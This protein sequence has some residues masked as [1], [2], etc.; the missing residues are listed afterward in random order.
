MVTCRFECRNYQNPANG[1]TVAVYRTRERN[2]VPM[3][4][5]KSDN[6]TWVSFTA[7]GTELPDL[8]S[9][10]IE[11]EGKW[12]NSERFGGQL[13]ADWF[14]VLLPKSRQ[15][16]VTYLSSMVKGIGPVMAETIVDRFGTDTFEVLE[17]EPE[18]LLEIK[19]ITEAK[20][21]AI[22]ESYGSSAELRELMTYLAPYRVTP[23]K[24]EK[25][26]EH[27]GLE[28]VKILQENPYRLCEIKGFGFL[29]VDP[30][31][32]AS[33]H[34]APDQPERVKAAL[35]YVLKEAE[36]DGH[37]YL[38]SQ[39]AVTKAERL[40][41]K[42]L[43]RGMVSR[44]VIIRAGNE[45]VLEDKLLQADKS[46]IFLKEN[47]EAEQKAVWNLIRLMKAGV[48]SYE[49][50]SELTEAQ[51][52]QG[53]VLAEK[54]REAVRMVFRS[55]V[56]IITGGPGKGK[57]TV[58]G[59]LLKVFEKKEKGKEVLLCAPTGRARK[60]LSESTG[61]PALTIHKALY[62]NVEDEEDVLEDEGLDEDLIIAD[63]FT[64]AD[65]SLASTLFAK[66]KSGARLVMVGDVDQLPSVGPG[67][68]FKELIDS[69]VI[70]VTVL[71][72]FFRQAKDSRIILNADLINRNQKRLLFGEDFQFYNAGDDKEAAKLIEA[73]YEAE[74]KRFDGNVDM[75][76]VL[77]PL[78]VNTAAGVNSLNGRLR[79]IANPPSLQK[80]EW[81]CGAVTY[82]E[83]DKVMQTQNTE[84]ISNGDIGR[85]VK[86]FSEPDGTRKMEVSF[87]EAVRSF[88]EE[89]LSALDHAYATSIHKSQGGE[90][91]V[92]I[93]PVLKCFYP[94]L[95]RN[96]YYTG[97]TRAR[98]K[99]ILI[100][101]RQA[102]AM[103]ISN[104]DAGK[105]NTLLA[106]RLRCEAFRQGLE[107]VAPAAA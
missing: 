23:K 35:H 75:V 107:M 32:M 60:R 82:R 33:S 15:G 38:E 58:L 28:A 8:E 14:R 88:Q 64:M 59:I 52:E 94:M 100:G 16:I 91:P 41:N 85:I 81:Q 78:R 95:K 83:G 22:K 7:V 70:P 87:G 19:G 73:L 11:M 25:I 42:A 56:S 45:M 47:R 68:V 61:Y 90:Y 49:I 46:A 43:P 86:I 48:D 29:T 97:I 80:A 63:E 17:K 71:D 2:K 36:K 92:V 20:L 62:L 74:L 54:Q 67:N 98:Q 37:L 104:T 66:I 79:E 99:V 51:A 34:F 6:G 65:M 27:F 18:R 84:D 1:Y 5:V 102:L 101:S 21:S 39:E 4:A 24:A 106:K 13:K 55:P 44:S 76:Q 3:A 9:V 105:R 69:G 10:E 96:V 53:L 50:E 77:S 103:A 93:I 30:I 72:V 26:Q 89:E 40:L 57:T 31:A 12:V